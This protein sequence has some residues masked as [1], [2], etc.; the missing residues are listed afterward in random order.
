MEM[1][2]LTC[3]MC[4]NSDLIKQDGVFVC[5][6]CGCKYT[7]EE[8]RKLMIEG[9]VDVSGSTVKIDK[10]NEIDNLLVVARRARDEG[11]Y[12][13]ASSHYD[14]ILKIDPD[15]WEANFYRT[16]CM[17]LEG[18]I[19]DIPNNLQLAINSASSTIKMLQSRETIDETACIEIIARIG[20]MVTVFI[21]S[22]YDLYAKNP[23]WREVQ[24]DKYGLESD[25]YVHNKGNYMQMQENL[26]G[27][28]TIAG[29]LYGEIVASQKTSSLVCEAIIQALEREKQDLG[30]LPKNPF[31]NEGFRYREF[32]NLLANRNN[33]LLSKVTES[34]KMMEQIRD[35]HREI[36]KKQREIEEQQRR[37]E[38]QRKNQAYWAAHKEEK[39]QLESRKTELNLKIKEVLS[40]M[41]P[42]QDEIKSLSLKKYDDVPSQ[43]EWN[44]L[45]AERDKLIE[46]KNKM[47][48]FKR[49]QKQTLQDQ[50]EAY[51]PKMERVK[52]KI[53]REKDIQFIKIE[54]KIVPLQEKLVPLSQEK[55]KLLEQVRKIDAELTSDR[56]WDISN[57]VAND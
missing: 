41:Q 14:D 45:Q 21:N 35:V 37:E 10:T 31:L 20:A 1:K 26:N 5:Q 12:A 22:Y 23:E 56:E 40:V 17:A 52:A 57:G 53:E 15:N 4:G 38:Q 42:I 32:Y 16:Y 49:K 51:T 36:E 29:T 13:R 24:L 8:A 28:L 2:R 25:S 54:D 9:K 39:E 27:V 44:M 7:V 33:A 47:G 3:E 19:I 6:S 46:E 30:S 48:F 11:N 50:I 43:A 55:E 18:R 34:K